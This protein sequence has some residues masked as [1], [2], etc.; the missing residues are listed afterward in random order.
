MSCSSTRQF[1]RQ[2][3][4]VLQLMKL[5]SAGRNWGAAHQYTLADSI[6]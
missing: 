1:Q 2:K 5:C 3:V 6:S 4:G